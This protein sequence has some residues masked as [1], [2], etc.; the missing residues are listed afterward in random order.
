M[1]PD[2]LGYLFKYR[3]WW[4]S[5]LDELYSN[6]QNINTIIAN[7]DAVKVTT[8]TDEALKVRLKGKHIF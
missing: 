6:I 2:Q 4:L 3:L 5:S 8:S 1:S 7:I